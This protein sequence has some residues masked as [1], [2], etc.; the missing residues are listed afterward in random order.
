MCFYNDD[1]DWVAEVYDE[2]YVRGEQPAKC[3]DC[4]REIKA[5]EWRREIFQ[6]EHEECQICEDIESDLYEDPDEIDE[7]EGMFG[8]GE[9]PHYYGESWHGVICRECNLL[10]ASIY[11]L[12]EKEGC[13]EYSR[14]PAFGE[15]QE[16]MA[17]DCSRWGDKKYIRHALEMFPELTTHKLLSLA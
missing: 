12:E 7:A 9:H 8:P 16:T 11:D 5:G 2:Q 1:Y 4:Y 13:P 15:L 10:R 3:F 14:Q 17:D 6:L